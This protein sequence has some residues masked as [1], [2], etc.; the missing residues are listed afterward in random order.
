MLLWKKLLVKSA[1]SGKRKRQ[2]KRRWRRNGNWISLTRTVLAARVKPHR[3]PVTYPCS[4]KA[5]LSSVAF[6]LS[7]NHWPY[8]FTVIY[9][10]TVVAQIDICFAPS[11]CSARDWL[12]MFQQ[13]KRKATH[14]VP[15][16][17]EAPPTP[18]RLRLNKSTHLSVAA[19]WKSSLPD[20]L[21]K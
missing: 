6:S 18:C 16:R 12:L 19:Y 9:C 1:L 14:E 2:R 17:R 15:A 3:R 7:L 10:S 13:T 4:N 8:W 5:L 21:K 11:F 20:S